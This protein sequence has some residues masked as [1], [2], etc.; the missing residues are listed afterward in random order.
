[1][2]L[3]EV[4]CMDLH[5]LQAALLHDSLEDTRKITAAKI[6]R[7]L[8]KEVV[9]IVKLLSKVPKEGY[10][11]RLMTFADWKTLMVKACDRLHNL[12]TLDQADEAFQKKQIEE[13]RTK[14]YQVLDRMV[15]SVPPEWSKGALYLR[16]EIKKIVRSYDKS[17]SSTPAKAAAK[18]RRP[19]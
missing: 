7:R 3:D 19:R 1:M 9:R 2:L 6:E 12:R 18:S 10:I 16:R 11:E 15:T 8:G 14:Y 4:H 5:M 13:T 17:L